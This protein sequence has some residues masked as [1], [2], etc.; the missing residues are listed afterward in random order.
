[1][2]ILY[3]D[4]SYK[5]VGACFEVYNELGFGFYEEV[6]HDALQREFTLQSIPFVHEPKVDIHYK[7]ELIS[8]KYEP[9]FVNYSKI[10]VELKAVKSIHDEHLAQVFN[11]LKATNFEL[12]I[13]INFGAKT[14]LEYKRIARSKTYS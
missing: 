14:G 11:Y 6:Y 2:G 9:D 8:R 4:E 5:I 1:M 12:G 13:L 7:G 3:K 10:I